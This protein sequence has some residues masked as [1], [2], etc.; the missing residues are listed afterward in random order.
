VENQSGWAKAGLTDGHSPYSPRNVENEFAAPM[1]R[2][3][4][5]VDQKVAR[6][7]LSICGLGYYL[8]EINGKRIGIMSWIRVHAARQAGAVRDARCE[9]SGAE[10]RE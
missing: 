10:W 7:T 8:I 1:L 3:T 9:Q 6:A 5:A 4:F 2:K